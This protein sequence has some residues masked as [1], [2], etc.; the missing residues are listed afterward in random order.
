MLLMMMMM[1]ERTRIRKAKR[2]KGSGCVVWGAHA[3]IWSEFLR[4]AVEKVL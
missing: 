3:L 1:M 4:G 2:A